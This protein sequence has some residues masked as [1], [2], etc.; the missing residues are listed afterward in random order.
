MLSFCTIIAG[1]YIPQ[2]MVLVDS[3]REFHPESNIYILFADLDVR[4]LPR[5]KI[6]QS[7]SYEQISI[8]DNLRRSFKYNVTEYCTSLKATFLKFLFQNGNDRVVYLDPDILVTNSLDKLNQYFENNDVLLTPHLDSPTP[9]DGKGPHFISMLLT[10]IY[11]LG[12]IALKKTPNADAFLNWWE[13]QLET[14][15]VDEQQR[16]LFTDQK[17]VDIAPSIFSGFYILKDTGYNAAPWNIHSRFLSCKNGVWLCNESPLYFFHFSNYRSKLPNQIAAYVTRDD[18]LS[19]PDLHSL[20]IIYT[21]K[22]QAY[23]HLGQ[24][25]DYRFNYY[26]DMS[27]IS[28]ATRLFYR[29]KSDV[30][31]NIPNPFESIYLQIQQRKLEDGVLV[32]LF[33]AIYRMPDIAKKF[34]KMATLFIK[35]KLN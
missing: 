10:G 7:V 28:N 31:W 27:K 16:G 35:R 29:E 3:L 21:E 4:S 8:K 15:S 26:S 9:E 25:I 6:Y 34:F 12:F 14:L 17:L 5:E 2:A 32:A 23:K 18:L 19:R 33:Y 24:K 11:N 20:Y 13:F 1:N 30:Y 22:N